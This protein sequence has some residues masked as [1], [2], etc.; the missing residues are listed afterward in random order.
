MRQ[1]NKYGLAI[2]ILCGDASTI[3]G[4]INLVKLLHH[5]H[6]FI[7][8]HVDR[9]VTPDNLKKL[10]GFLRMNGPYGGVKLISNHYGAWGDIS[11]VQMT[12]DGMR[13]FDKE[14]YGFSHFLLLS[15]NTYPLK[16][17]TTLLEFFNRAANQSFMSILGNRLYAWEEMSEFKKARLPIFPNETSLDGKVKGLSTVYFGSQWITLSYETF[18]WIL[19]SD[20]TYNLL[21][22]MSKFKIPDESFFQTLVMHSPYN[23]SVADSGI[24]YEVWRLE[25][26]YPPYDR[27]PCFLGT[28]DI[29][30][31][32]ESKGL[33]IRKVDADVDPDVY[34]NL[35]I[36]SNHGN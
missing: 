14:T 9:K 8:I 22:F 10:Q 25:C 31:I 35:Q 3:N 11:L 18:K 1:V 7:T 29:P 23:T 2:L 5:K 6:T 27:R 17:I 20:I 28:K 16:N 24:H 32:I 15:G 19:Q 33:F 36:I 13:A 4:A 26:S 12:L 30:H 34:T 21:V